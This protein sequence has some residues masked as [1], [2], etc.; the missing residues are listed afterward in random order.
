MAKSELRII[1]VTRDFLQFLCA[2]ICS[3][4]GNSINNTIHWSH[5][6]DYSQT[7]PINFIKVNFT[8]HFQMIICTMPTTTQFQMEYSLSF[9]T[10]SSDLP[11][12][13]SLPLLSDKQIFISFCLLCGFN[14]GIQH[15]HL[16]ARIHMHPMQTLSHQINFCLLRTDCFEASSAYFNINYNRNKT[17]YCLCCCRLYSE[18]ETASCM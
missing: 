4:S 16:Y 12:L 17:R 18:T 3:N 15:H 14:V 13:P 7:F 9:R 2:Q 11:I 1:Y 6:F 5:A 10:F 8:I